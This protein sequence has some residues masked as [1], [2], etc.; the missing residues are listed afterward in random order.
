MTEKQELRRAVRAHIEALSAAERQRL[1]ASAC[2]QLE[3][4][5]AWRRART[6]LLYAAL[7]D[8]VDTTPLIADAVRQDKRVVLPVVEGERIALRYYE[9]AA[10]MAT[11]RYSILEPTAEA[12]RL[13]ETDVLDLAVIPGRAF[14]PDGLRLGRGRG[15]YDRLL[16]A[17]RCPT[18]GLA[19]PC[20]M[21]DTLPADV[22]DVRVG[23]VVVG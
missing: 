23:S 2:R 17:L 22:W 6:V 12:E 18:V 4:T 20:Q 10:R 15:Y 13:D 1:S 5:D 7:A 21:V 11:G 8:E 9:G 19:W 3:A 14:T 16:P